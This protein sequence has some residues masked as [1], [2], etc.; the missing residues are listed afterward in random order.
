MT[1]VTMPSRALLTPTVAMPPTR[2]IVRR[3]DH[4]GS[5]RRE[6]EEEP[7]WGGGH[8]TRIGYRNRQD[9]FPGL[10]HKGDEKAEGRFEKEAQEEIDRL[11]ERV[12]KG[13]LI[14]FRDAITHQKVT[15]A[16]FYYGRSLC[17]Q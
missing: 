9:R 1:T 15:D 16:H 11:R 2:H 13:D 12:R 10:T 17:D 14:N 4:P 6:I 5:S 3:K 8:Q 7:D